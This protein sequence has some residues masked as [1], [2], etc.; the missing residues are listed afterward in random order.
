MLDYFKSIINQD[1]NPVVICNLEHEI[2]YMN[3]AAIVNYEK[4][5]GRKLL[6]KNL[7]LCH[8]EKSQSRI[9]EVIKWFKDRKDNNIVYTSYDKKKNT[10]IYMVALRDE[11]D[12]LIG[13]YEKHENRNGETMEM[14][15]IHDKWGLVVK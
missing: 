8:N 6:G 3:P 12:N 1:K 15:D 5:G 13:Y 7:L 14:Y 9:E 2:I 10:D 11:K 4:W